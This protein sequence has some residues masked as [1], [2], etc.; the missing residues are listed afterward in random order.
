M[1]MVGHLAD[2]VKSHSAKTVNTVITA[3]T[4]SFHVITRSLKLSGGGCFDSTDFLNK[5]LPC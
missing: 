3:N 5:K 2:I 1:L 4:F